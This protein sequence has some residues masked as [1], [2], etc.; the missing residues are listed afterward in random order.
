MR[1]F[2]NDLNRLIL[3]APEIIAQ[4]RAIIRQTCTPGAPLE[5]EPASVGFAIHAKIRVTS[6]AP[7]V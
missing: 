5:S 6:V 7:K 3:N 1:D 4:Q 2:D